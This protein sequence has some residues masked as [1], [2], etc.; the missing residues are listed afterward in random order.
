M[1]ATSIR[2]SLRF[3]FKRFLLAPALLKAVSSSER[4]RLEE[5]L[6]FLFCSKTSISSYLLNVVFFFTLH[7][8]H[9]DLFTTLIGDLLVW[10]SCLLTEGICKHL[11]LILH[12]SSCLIC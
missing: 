12:V 1:Q 10:L 3:F 6:F 5:S 4:I 8:L 11:A 7:S 9:M 2:R